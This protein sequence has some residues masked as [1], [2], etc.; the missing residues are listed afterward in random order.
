[1]SRF[2]YDQRW[3]GTHG[4]GRFASEVRKRLTGFA[5]LAL[6]GSPTHPL[7]ALRVGFSLRQNRAKVFLTPGFNVPIAACCPV[8][9][10][11]HDL[12]HV[13]FADERTRAKLA[14]YRYVQR[15]VVRRSPVT[16]TVSEY[17][18]QQIIEWYGVPESRVVCVGNGISDQFTESGEAVRSERP[19]FLYV[20]NTKPHK[21]V[22]TLLSAMSLL[23]QECDAELVLVAKNCRWLVEQ[24]AAANL[25]SR[26]TT[27]SN[28]DDRELASWYRGAAALVLPSHY[29]GFGLPI[30]E[31]MACGCPVIGSNR[32]SIPEV[33][34]GSGLLFE[35]SDDESLADKMRT[36]L[37]DASRR[38][39][40]RVQGL[41]RSAAFTWDLVAS[42]VRDSIAPH[43]S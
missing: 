41:A 9:T 12:I 6:G 16:L 5:D 8:I 33:L 11:I 13:H 23:V 27:I 20:G 24:T 32:T 37:A 3:C 21:N 40:L 31:A 43:L 1:M 4:I 34:A 30:L 29:E 7:D 18:R 14:Y 10:T 17:S 36:L 22:K 15:P 19:Y 39:E 26:V 38:A 2:L 28:L 25:T 42:R 35:P